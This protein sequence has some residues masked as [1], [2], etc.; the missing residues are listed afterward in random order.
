MF[1][2]SPSLEESGVL[3]RFSSFS[4]TSFQL[5]KVYS[6][7]E[8]NLLNVNASSWLECQSQCYCSRW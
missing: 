7:L 2:P 8:C 6:L 3:G 1:F 5:H 4:F